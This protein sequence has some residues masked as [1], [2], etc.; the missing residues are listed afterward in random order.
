[1]NKDPHIIFI[2]EEK[3][4]RA[5]EAWHIFLMFYFKIILVGLG[6]DAWNENDNIL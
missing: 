2:F 6:I 3:T 1:M 5:E 4:N